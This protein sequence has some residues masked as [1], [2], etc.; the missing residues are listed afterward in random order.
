M[1]LNI[2]PRNGS[3]KGM[4]ICENNMTTKQYG[5]ECKGDRYYK[6]IKNDETTECKYMYVHKLY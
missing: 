1:I 2:D 4:A 3:C 6:T 5:C